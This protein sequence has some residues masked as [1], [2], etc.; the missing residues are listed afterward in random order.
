MCQPTSLLT[1]FSPKNIFL[2]E[3]V[4][5]FVGLGASVP[6]PRSCD[7]SHHC[8]C[9]DANTFCASGKAMKCAYNEVTDKD[10]LHTL[11]KLHLFSNSTARTMSA[12]RRRA[13]AST[14]PSHTRSVTRSPRAARG[15]LR[16]EQRP[17]R[18][19]QKPKVVHEHVRRGIHEDAITLPGVHDQSARE[20]S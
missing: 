5:L 15:T 8:M 9:V 14:W 2:L 10:T 3:L 17:V 20:N 4:L 13:C 18:E 11:H 19:Q 16:H 12:V 7:A 1:I 6:A